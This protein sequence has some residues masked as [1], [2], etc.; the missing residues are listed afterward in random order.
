[1][2]S[3]HGLKVVQ[4]KLSCQAGIFDRSSRQNVFCLGEKL[5]CCFHIIN[6]S[7]KNIIAERYN[8]VFFPEGGL[9]KVSLCL[10]SELLAHHLGL[11]KQ[12]KRA[13][14]GWAAV[15]HLCPLT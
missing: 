9:L 15:S 8:G 3:P 11:T 1:M 7:W 4:G 2:A 12:F 14:K 6:E 10:E 5:L 13:E